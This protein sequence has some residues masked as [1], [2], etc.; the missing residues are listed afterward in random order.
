MSYKQKV[1]DTIIAHFAAVDSQALKALTADQPGPNPS[2]PPSAPSLS[3]E[4]SPKSFE[5]E[6]YEELESGRLE[7]DTASDGSA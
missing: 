6:L 7:Y 4:E 3:A 5:D 1:F 2:S